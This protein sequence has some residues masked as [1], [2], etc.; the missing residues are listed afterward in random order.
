MKRDER[1]MEREVGKQ[2][3]QT[4]IRLQ[5]GSICKF[6]GNSYSFYAESLDEFLPTF[7]RDNLFNCTDM[8]R[9]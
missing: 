5:L 2:G 8:F 7:I 4:S 6:K 3:G 1:K 9:T